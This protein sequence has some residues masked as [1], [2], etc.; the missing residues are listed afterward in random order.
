M[1]HFFPIKKVASTVSFEKNALQNS[2][3][4]SMCHHTIQSSYVNNTAT[5][6]N[7]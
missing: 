3:N 4:N 1:A 2:L 6:K 5:Q 7:V